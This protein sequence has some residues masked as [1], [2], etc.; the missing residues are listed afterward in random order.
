MAGPPPKDPAARRNRRTTAGYRQLP[1][2][3]RPGDPP[4]WP[5][6]PQLVDEAELWLVLWATPQATEWERLGFTRV[7]ARYVRVVVEAD[8]PGANPQKLAEARQLEDRL[9]LTPM[10]MMK[11]RW[12]TDEPVEEEPEPEA[13]APAEPR[14]YV[15]RK[16]AQ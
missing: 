12:E 15:P 10:A 6:G 11:L 13:E 1:A 8:Q 9:G 3:G 2:A 4:P 7:V 16:E 5:L 14:A